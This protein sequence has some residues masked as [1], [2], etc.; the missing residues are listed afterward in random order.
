[1]RSVIVCLL[2]AGLARADSSVPAA[3]A[4]AG[5]CR[6]EDSPYQRAQRS[7]AVKEAQKKMPRDVYFMNVGKRHLLFGDRWS[8]KKLRTIVYDPSGE[9]VVFDYA[10]APA[11][12]VETA[13]GTFAGVL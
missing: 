5:T 11:A 4:A 2:L 13:D 10:S 1:M 12:L 3:G 8:G 9:R 6:W 7:D